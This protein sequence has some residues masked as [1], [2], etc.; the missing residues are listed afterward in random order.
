MNS[1]P[2]SWPKQRA[3]KRQRGKRKSRA[4]TRLSSQETRLLH[5]D[6]RRSKAERGLLRDTTARLR[7]IPA[8][9]TSEW[10]HLF[11]S[12]SSLPVGEQKRRED[13]LLRRKAVRDIMKIRENAGLEHADQTELWEGSCIDIT[14]ELFKEF[15]KEHLSIYGNIL[16]NGTDADA[17]Q[18]EWLLRQEP[19]FF[20]RE[21]FTLPGGFHMDLD[22]EDLKWPAEN[23]GSAV[24]YPIELDDDD[25]GMLEQFSDGE[26]GDLDEGEESSDEEEEADYE[27][28]SDNEDTVPQDQPQDQ[29]QVRRSRPG[30]G[31][32]RDPAWDMPPEPVSDHEL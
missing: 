31:P 26:G 29:P 30:A 10:V 6:R 13:D 3:P 15:S 20:E 25:N 22:V 16:E 21:D 32:S 8:S 1:D 2:L 11:R 27:D 14:N 18:H 24:N 5:D 19:A 7:Q 4:A 17:E 28:E 23:N 12:K 9:Q